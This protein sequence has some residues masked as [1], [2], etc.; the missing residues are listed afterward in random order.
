M[1]GEG[2][3]SGRGAGGGGAVRDD[4]GQVRVRRGLPDARHRGIDSGLGAA[5]D[6]H[7]RALGRKPLGDGM[8]DAGGRPGHQC[9][10]ASKPQI[11]GTLTL[12]LRSA[13]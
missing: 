7:A 1:S 10:L 8:A 11:H 12:V 2:R 13:I 9:M 4:A 3:R 5:G 6:D